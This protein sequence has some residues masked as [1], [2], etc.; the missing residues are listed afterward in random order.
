MK[1]TV[2][3]SDLQGLTQL[4]LGAVSTKAG[5]PILSNILLNC[6]KNSLEMSATDLEV[7]VKS[8]IPCQGDEPGDICIPAKTFGDLVKAL[9]DGDVVIKTLKN[10][11]TSIVCAKTTF[12]VMGV[13]GDD[14]PKLPDIGKGFVLELEQ[15]V[16]KRLFDLTSFA[17]SHDDS[18]P[19][20]KGVM[21]VIKAQQIST[22]ATDGR[23]LA[24]ASHKLKKGSYRDRQVII[25]LKAVSELIRALKEE[26]MVKVHFGDKYLMFEVDGTIVTTRL[27]EGSF[28]DYNQVIPKTS[29]GKVTIKRESLLSAVRRSNILTSVHSQAVRVDIQ[30]GKMVV[31]GHA[32]DM[33]DAVDEIEA[34]YSGEAFSI[35]FNPAYLIDVLRLPVWEDIVI[36]FTEQGKPALFKV[37]EDYTYVV[38]PM[39][40]S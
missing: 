40:I 37:T 36:E 5:M 4:V 39:Q 16:L 28:P 10:N 14:F 27:I 15:S 24:V 32:P 1:A 35:G 20:L 26:G 38:M 8:Q 2:K 23:R 30:K 7:A 29:K 18:R 12:K 33:G 34:D 3:Q 9:N 6:S 25:P 17:V 13:S 19:S 22:V 21:V 31:S 11:S